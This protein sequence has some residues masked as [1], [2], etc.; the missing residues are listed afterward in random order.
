MAIIIEANRIQTFNVQIAPKEFKKAVCNPE[1]LSCFSDQDLIE[2][3][4]ALQ[5][6]LN[7]R[8]ETP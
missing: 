2:I 8:K 5:T 4:E 1:T 3:M 7:S 6:E